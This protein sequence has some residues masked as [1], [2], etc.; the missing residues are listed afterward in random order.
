MSSK[1]IEDAFL[2]TMESLERLHSALDTAHQAYSKNLREYGDRRP[3]TKADLAVRDSVAH[4]FTLG[5]YSSLQCWAMKAAI[6][7]W[8]PPSKEPEKVRSIPFE[9]RGGAE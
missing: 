3:T 8:R 5:N 9:G 6:A 4:L 1:I 2:E 7:A